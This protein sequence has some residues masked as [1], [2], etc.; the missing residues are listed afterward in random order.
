MAVDTLQLALW[1]GFVADLPRVNM[2]PFLPFSPCFQNR[3][4]FPQNLQKYGAKTVHKRSKTVIA[5]GSHCAYV[6][7]I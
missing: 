4:F 2:P 5:V 1:S 3:H 6:M 7:S